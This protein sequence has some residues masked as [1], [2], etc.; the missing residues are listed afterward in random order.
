MSWVVSCHCPF[1]ERADL[2][3]HVTL[4]SVLPSVPPSARNRSDGVTS[5]DG[6]FTV[7]LPLGQ[8]EPTR[9]KAPY[10]TA[11]LFA[12]CSSASCARAAARRRSDCQRSHRG[13]CH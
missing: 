5:V 2:R 10:A 4:H 6:D 1:T 9:E 13:H 7:A 3:K 8:A 11:T 12:V